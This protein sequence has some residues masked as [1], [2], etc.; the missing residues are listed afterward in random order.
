MGGYRKAALMLS[1]L[2]E[3]D[4]AWMLARLAEQ[5]RERLAPLLAEVREMGLAVDAA[6]MR[7]LAVAA[8]APPAARPGA[9]RPIEAASA[10]AVHEVLAREPD[11][12]LAALA[13]ARDWPWRDAFLRLLGAERRLQLQHALPS[14]VELR[15]KAL[16][17]LV[18][19]I[20]TRLAE[21]LGESDQAVAQPA[22][23]RP[24]WRRALPWRR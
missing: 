2:A 17:A 23:R 15:P 16:E 11:W 12:L 7:E 8:E 3:G 21:R 6:T 1:S 4:R 20:E 10:Q 22:P 9:P 5:E 18:A 14:G 24:L 13:R 19:G